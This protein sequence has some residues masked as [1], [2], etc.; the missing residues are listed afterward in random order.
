MTF[1][2]GSLGAEGA[3]PRIQAAVRPGATPRWQVQVLLLAG[4]LIW[5]LM[6]LALLTHQAADPGFSSSG[7]GG[8]PGNRAG[9]LGAWASDLALFLLGYSVWVLMAVGLRAWLA[10]LA[11]WLRGPGPTDAP[12]LPGLWF[13]LGWRCC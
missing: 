3:G 5:L 11:L 12:V 8:A 4:G 10:N 6:A 13:W 2:L 9:L 7:Q 1:P